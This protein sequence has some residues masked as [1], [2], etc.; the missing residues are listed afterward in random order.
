[1]VVS[2]HMRIVQE[3]PEAVKKWRE[4]NKDSSLDLSGA[5]LCWS[6]L[7]GVDLSG[8][9]LREAKLIGAALRNSL[10]CGANLSKADLSGADLSRADL[11]EA[12]LSESELCK[13]DLYKVNL[14]GAKLNKCSLYYT[15]LLSVKVNSETSFENIENAKKCKI[16]RYTIACLG[17][18]RGC[19]TDGDLMMMKIHDDV[20]LLR[21]EFSG[22]WGAIH[23]FA[24][25]SFS[26]PYLW[27]LI[28]HRIKASFER[29]LN[30]NSITLFTGLLRYIWNGGIGWQKGWNFEFI[31]F[32]TFIGFFIYNSLRASLLYKT[33]KLETEQNVSGLP[34]LYSLDDSKRWRN[35]YYVVK[36]GVVIY[37]VL[38]I[39][40]V[41]HFLQMRFNV[42]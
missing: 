30:E 40:N 35:I 28:E 24:I 10:L 34:A 22:I 27:F 4:E 23:L 37:L 31:S 32:S 42:E 1:M 6:N 8:A 19:L 7:I 17:K 14:S 41:Y 3:G 36:Y 16:D 18:N 20:A 33:K 21:S 13:A 25:I 39:V 15:N 5:D 11:R 38:V 2:A 12:N 26:I 9:N 29:D